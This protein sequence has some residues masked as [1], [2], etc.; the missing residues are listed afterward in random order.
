[1]NSTPLFLLQSIG[2]GDFQIQS[3]PVHGV[4]FLIGLVVVVVLIIFLNKSTKVKNSTVFKSGA[5]N[6]L[7]LRNSGIRSLRKAAIKYGIER[8][9]RQFLSNMFRKEEIDS[10]I[11]FSS[12]KNIDEGFSKITQALNRE[13]G[14]DDDIR[15]LFA[16]RNKIEYYITAG[17]AAE[18][19][20]DE[21]KIVRRYKRAETNIPVVFYLVIETEIRSGLKKIKKLSLDGTKCTGTI[22]DISSGGCAVS[23]RNP[24]KTGSRIKL[25]FKIGRKSLPA[26]A[27]ILRINRNRSGN[28]LH[29]RFL[30]TS[31]KTLNAINTLVYNYSNI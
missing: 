25:E 21:K 26:L 6:K 15:K 5:V 22:I 24:Y 4:A 8:N 3:N 12:V 2:L 28:V 1:M 13:E 9:E 16:I 14:T 17:E 20:V 23:T 18:T 19:G 30:K 27:Q 29:T 7:Q 10:S 11:V 31:V